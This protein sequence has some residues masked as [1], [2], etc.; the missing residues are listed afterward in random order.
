MK[1]Y[2]YLF[3]ALTCLKLSNANA[4]PEADTA[5]K[6]IK[7]TFGIV[8]TFM[9]D[10]P[11]SGIAGAWE[12]MKG[13]Q[14]NSN[15]VI[16]PKYKELIGMAV[17]AQIPCRYCSYFHTEAAKLNKANKNEMDEAIAVAGQTYRWGSFIT[18]MQISESEFKSDIDKMLMFV[19]R[20]MAKQAME[21][22]PKVVAEKIQSPNDVYADVK[23]TYGFVPN[24][25][26]QYPANSIV[27]AWK[28]M[29]A[30]HMNPDS[31]IP[32]KYNDLI[33]LAVS[34]QI[35][36]NLC[37][38]Y[39]T[40]AA[41]QEGATKEEIAEAVALAGT[42]RNWSTILNGHMMNEKDF[43]GEVDQIMKF[44]KDK[45]SKEVTLR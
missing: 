39:H 22:E 34:A 5:Y 7:Q 45:M 42:V 40:Q 31:A 6:E 23:M 32:A 17:A 37:V 8:P 20:Q 1:I 13:V 2:F 15:S 25:I 41:I 4:L 28:E 27:G 36:C 30:L 19:N 9:K 18:G 21:A 24:F 11:Q 33:G 10:Y 14:L 38:Y 26:Q 12:E 3:I 43:R 44:S 16:P 29:K 35:P